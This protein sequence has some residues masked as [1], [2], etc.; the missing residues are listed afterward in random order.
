ME[1]DKSSSFK[2]EN[3]FYLTARESRMARALAHYELFKQVICVPG[4]IVECGVF[5]GVSFMRF[6]MFMNLFEPQNARKIIGFDSFDFFPDTNYEADKNELNLFKEETG[7]KSISK[8]HLEHYIKEKG[9][10]NFE[11][12]KGDILETVPAY[13]KAHPELKIALLNI[14]TDI[15][16]PANVIIE[17]LV[18]KVVK[19]GIIVF[20]DYGIFPGETKVADDFC[21]RTGYRLK[22]FPFSK[23]PS[24]LIIN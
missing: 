1:F 22:K 7:G 8:E 4:E 15:F 24:Y 16:E 10:K 18:P 12:V 3:G 13:V 6:M 20:D 14:D 11:L 23:V 19:G 17:H 21:E 2:Y 9:H 5:K